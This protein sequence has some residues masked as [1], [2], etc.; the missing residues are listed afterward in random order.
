MTMPALIPGIAIVASFAFAGL[1]FGLAYF[2][3]LRRAVDFHAPDRGRLVPAVLTL[4]RLAAAILFLGIAAR[5]GPL[6][7]LSSFIGFLLARAVALR[8][9]RGTA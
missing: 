8:V 3:V 6:P 1:A 9:V 5:V 2:A 7:L 4:G